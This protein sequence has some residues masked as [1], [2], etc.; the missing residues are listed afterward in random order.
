M[1]LR[2][3]RGTFNPEKGPLHFYVA[4]KPTLDPTA[5]QR[6]VEASFPIDVAVSVTETGEL[7]DL[8][9]SLPKLCFTNK[10]S[11]MF[12]QRTD[13]ASVIEERV[14]VTVPRL[15]GG[16]V[17]EASARLEIVGGRRI[18]CLGINL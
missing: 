7:A 11:L 15:D 18:I 1:S 9:F 10:D 5:E 17:F 8:A 6:G 4:F 14:F 12:L 16:F 3:A 13:S 2:V